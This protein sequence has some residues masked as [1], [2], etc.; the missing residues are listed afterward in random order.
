M[1]YDDDDDDFTERGLEGHKERGSH[2]PKTSMRAATAILLL[3]AMAARAAVAL[4]APL[5]MPG[6]S[7]IGI[8]MKTGSC[9]DLLLGDGRARVGI[10]TRLR[11]GARGLQGIEGPSTVI[12]EVRSSSKGMSPV[13]YYLDSQGN[14]G[15]SGRGQG[16]LAKPRSKA[17]ARDLSTMALIIALKTT[18]LPGMEPSNAHVC[19]V[20]SLQ[21]G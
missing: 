6:I 9:L 20:W 4:Q 10:S 13:E 12:S 11:G 2:P 15:A 7:P 5:K 3:L 1:I 18:F 19:I 14:T 16:V 8:P 17:K 21:A